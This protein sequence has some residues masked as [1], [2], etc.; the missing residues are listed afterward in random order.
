MKI[1]PEWVPDKPE[2]GYA[3]T[4]QVGPGSSCSISL[5]RERGSCFMLSAG[6]MAK[7]LEQAGITVMGYEESQDPEFMDGEV[8]LENSLSVQV[9]RDYACLC[10][11][12]VED[13]DYLLEREELFNEADFAAEVAQFM[14][15]RQG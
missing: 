8:A 10:H 11:V 7:A 1:S 14:K 3:G 6:K 12:D 4:S 2:M 5:P 9:G 15:T 13:I